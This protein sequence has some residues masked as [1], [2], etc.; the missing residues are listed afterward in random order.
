MK[1]LVAVLLVFTLAFSILP[2]DLIHPAMAALAETLDN[3]EMMTTV[4]PQRKSDNWTYYLT[5]HGIAV[6]EGYD[7]DVT[8]LKIP[9]KI[10]GY[11]VG[12]LADGAFA[13]QTRLTS[14]TIPTQVFEI[15]DQAFF[16]AANLRVTCYDGSPAKKWAQRNGAKV[17]SLT[18]MYLND[19]IID[20]SGVAGAERI[21]SGDTMTVTS[22][23]SYVLTAG[24]VFFFT[25]TDKYGM[26]FWGGRVL[27][28]QRGDGT[29]TVTFE[30][31][32]QQ[33]LIERIVASSDMDGIQYEFE[34]SAEMR[35]G[36]EAGVSACSISGNC[37]KIL[38]NDTKH[39]FTLKV[40]A[41]IK[42]NFDSTIGKSLKTNVNATLT[43]SF[44]TNQK[45]A[46]SFDFKAGDIT[47]F[48]T[49]LR[50]FVIHI[51]LIVKVEVDGSV[52]VDI[53]KVQE[54]NWNYDYKVNGFKI[55]KPVLTNRTTSKDVILE[56]KAKL[57]AS[58]S[59]AMQVIGI[60][61]MTIAVEGGVVAD[62][63]ANLATR[64]FDVSLHTYG[65]A[66]LSID[67]FGIWKKDKTYPIPAA[68]KS[69]FEAHFEYNSSTKKL[70]KFKYKDCKRRP[71][72]VKFVLNGGDSANSYTEKTVAWDTT[73]TV[74]APTRKG[75]NFKG[76]YTDQG[77]T[78]FWGKTSGRITADTTLYAKWE[79]KYVPVT[80]IFLNKTAAEL[81]T[82]GSNR[83]VQL[84]CT[85]LPANATDKTVTYTSSNPKVATV[86]KG[87]VTAVAPGTTTI[88]ATSNADKKLVSKCTVTVKQYVTGLAVSVAD[89]EIVKTATTTVQAVVTPKN[90]TNQQY[91]W[92]S[93]NKQVATVDSKGVVTGV[94]TGTAKIY[95]TAQDGSGVK[96]SAEVRVLPLPVASIQPEG[97][98]VTVWTTGTDASVQ[99]KPTVLPE[100]ADD[101]TLLW[102]SDDM[103]IADVDENGV[104]TGVTAGTTTIRAAAKSAPEVTA[105][106]EVIVKQGA[107]FLQLDQESLQL[108]PGDTAHLTVSAEPKDASEQHLRW[109]SSN[110][111]V[112]TV[113]EEGLVT[114]VGGGAA[115]ISVQ[116]TEGS[117]CAAQCQVNVSGTPVS[118]EPDPAV[119]VTG[120]IL[121]VTAARLGTKGNTTLQLMAA[122]QPA[123][124]RN[125][126]VVWSSSNPAVAVVDQNGVVTAVAAGE[127]DIQAVS[128]DNGNIS[129]TA[130]IVVEQR[131]ET[132]TLEPAS[133]TVYKGEEF[134]LTAAIQ[135]EAAADQRVRWLSDHPEIAQVTSKGVVR[136]IGVGT[137][138][139]TAEVL[140]GSGVC[141][142]MQV[143]VQPVPVASVSLDVKEAQM[144]TSGTLRQLQLKAAVLPAAA[145]DRSLTWTSSNHDAATVDE[146]GLVTAQ[147]VGTAIIT[148]TSRSDAQKSAQCTVTVRQY[149]TGIEVTAPQKRMVPEDTMQLTAKVTPDNASNPAI[150]WSSSQP[151]VLAVDEQGLLKALQLG[152]ATITA[153]AQDGSG[154]IGTITIEVAEEPVYTV[155]ISNSSLVLYTD[156]EDQA[157]QLT[158]E[159]L[160]VNATN[161]YVSWSSSAPDVAYVDG[162]GR[163]IGVSA[164]TAVIRVA[165]SANPEAFAECTVT[166]KQR[167]T[168]VAILAD[169][170]VMQMG[171][172]MQ[173]TA[174]VA[175][176]DATVSNV[177]WKSDN[178][179]VVTVNAD[180]LVKA[181]DV[182]T[183][184][185]TA[186]AT[187]GSGVYGTLSLTVE[188]WLSLSGEV[189][190]AKLYLAGSSDVRL[191]EL[192]VS[193]NAAQRLSD[194][195]LQPVWTLTGGGEHT[196]VTLEGYPVS[197]MLRDGDEKFMG[198][199]LNVAELLSGGTDTYTLT[200][201][202][203]DYS[204]STSFKVTCDASAYA[205]KVT[206]GFNDVTLSVG[207]ALMIPATPVGNGTLP[208]QLTLSVTGDVEDLELTQSCEGISVKANASSIYT[209]YVAY[210]TANLAYTTEVTLR[211]KGEDGLI[212]L[213][214]KSVVMSA[215][216]VSMLVDEALDLSAAGMYG[217]ETV[218]CE[219]VWSSSD[220]T[221]V[222]VDQQGHVTAKA[223]GDA[224]IYATVK[225]GTQYGWCIV[226]VGHLLQLTQ[227]EVEL[228]VNT[229][230]TQNTELANITLTLDSCQRIQAMGLQPVWSLDKT[231][232]NSVELAVQELELN[233]NDGSIIA[234]ALLRMVRCYAAGD[235]TY[236]LR[237]TVGSYT[238]QA[239][240]MI[241]AYTPKKPMPTQ[242][243]L[244][245]DTY[246]AQ[247]DQ[248]VL[249]MTAVSAEPD[250][251]ALP[252]DCEISLDM[253]ASFSRA[254]KDVTYT[255]EGIR[256]TFTKS[257]RYTGN[258]VFSGTNYSYEAPF[259]MTVADRDGNVAVPVD[260]VSISETVQHM[261][262]GDTLQMSAAVLPVEAGN[263]QIVWSSYDDAVAS[264]DENGLV[265]A[266]AAGMTVIKAGTEDS[267][268]FD[269]CAIFVED[270][271]TM[272]STS[273][274]LQVYLEGATHTVLNSYYLSYASSLRSAGKQAQWSLKRVSGSCL[275]L[276]FKETTAEAQ[277]GTVLLGAEVSL[278]GLTR[279]GIAVYDLTCTVGDETAT[280]RLTV[281]AL[282]RADVLPDDI[283]LITRIYKAKA[284]ELIVLD[285]EF[286]C[287]PA[288][289]ALPGDMRLSL[290]LDAQGAAA[291]NA[292]DYYISMARSALS[293]SQPGTYSADCVIFCG[294]VR[295]V[296]PVTFCIADESGFVPVFA[297]KL[298]C[299]PSELFMER[300][301]TAQLKTVVTPANATEQAVTYTS[302]NEGVAK[303][304]EKGLVTAV[305]NGFAQIRITPEDTHIAPVVCN[306]TVEKGF[307]VLAS[308]NG[309]TMYL[310]GK[311]QTALGYFALSDG[312]A[313]RLAL[314]GLYPEWKVERK[315]GDAAV[316]G[317]EITEDNSQ[318]TLMSEA[319]LRSGT[320]V[321][322]VSCTAGAYSWKQDF[323]L[324]VLDA[325]VQAPEQVLS[326]TSSVNMAVGEVRTID[327]TPVCKPEGTVLPEAIAENSLYSGLGD[328]YQALDFEHYADNGDEVTVAFTQPGTYL[329]AR[330]WIN[331]N[332]QYSALC[333][334]TVGGEE[335][336]SGLL[337]TSE[338]DCTVY[339]GGMSAIAA[340]VS[341][342]DSMANELL[343]DQVSWE[344][345]R[346]SGSSV[347]AA[348]VPRKD[349]ADLYVANVKSTGDDVWRLTYKLGQ[350]SES[351]DF[352]IHAIVPRSTLPEA[353]ILTNDSFRARAGEWMYISLN[354]A[355]Q[356]AGSRLPDTGRDFWTLQLQDVTDSGM[357]EIEN[358]DTGIRVRFVEVGAYTGT[359][360]YA[361]GNVWYEV[362][363]YFT[364]TDEEDEER[365]YELKLVSGAVLDTVWLDGLTDVSVVNLKLADRDNG[366]EAGAAA[367]LVKQHG[368]AW[369]VQVNSGAECGT[370]AIVE[371]VPGQA[372][373]VLTS[374]EHT[375]EMQY[376]VS[377]TVAGQTYTSQRTLHVVG[378]ET[379]KPVL[380]LSRNVYTL[381]EGETI[382]IDRRIMDMDHGVQLASADSSCWKNEAAIAAMG[383]GVETN[384]D[385]WQVTFYE[386]GEY[387]TSVQIVAGNLK[388]TLPLTFIVTA[389]GQATSGKTLMMPGKLVEIEEEAFVGL[390]IDTIDLRGSA[391]MVIGSRAFADNSRLTKV[392]LPASVRTIADDAFAGS[393]AAVIVCPAG[394]YAAAWASAHGL[395]V[396]YAK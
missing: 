320:D 178:A 306:V 25:G 260:S 230:G 318:L 208:E 333:V 210:E 166:V 164:G 344:L 368:A 57:G 37:T 65:D 262:V 388:Y 84:G 116:T 66:T 11:P 200:C 272:D 370:L 67:F 81:Y 227:N 148:A 154:V 274:T 92:T 103:S 95:A 110:P 284:N 367:A 18:N 55:P 338:T 243:A 6:I 217:S 182:G 273:D 82:T 393:T 309:Y 33:S 380:N 188:Q 141:A 241:H 303:V 391:I 285:T 172:T 78:K 155:Q 125:T 27:N 40:V 374:L 74:S 61:V 86:S 290:E 394:S 192:M 179:K 294:N 146:N 96:G 336:P 91:T 371:T 198:V 127:T 119:A 222:S 305:A 120:I 256:I 54:V 80:Q 384:Q 356:P 99:L 113:T 202:A 68:S 93:D 381:A 102:S 19:G 212:R 124:A 311:P 94:G 268:I 263:Q 347:T 224:M 4:S 184:T 60:D 271:L 266:H 15:G 190:D 88:T 28:V 135:P 342:T 129:V 280:T 291:V 236:I 312:T 90:A 239:S 221:V 244:V 169:T 161:K 183:A 136:P 126:D 349:G 194:A 287:V 335:R 331:M 142:S 283:Q 390:P 340:T 1:R 313:K 350:Y 345:T 79:S 58:I 43:T 12:K 373:V 259:T 167:V 299:L 70:D 151:R 343:E 191:A 240:V 377:C 226:H 385:T 175:P 122:V 328:F 330:T 171:D 354:A 187:D 63:A 223:P 316:F 361:A 220:E 26:N 351:I 250:G 211:V 123:N 46:K 72:S 107:Y 346:I 157:F 348:V 314:A 186:A 17:N 321:Y 231:N 156:G 201:T 307:S 49:Y 269:S 24:K 159:V 334:I 352:T 288:T 144:Y 205:D 329:L 185:I 109:T 249:L 130:H 149:V 255:A 366:V 254:V 363:V 245:T 2:L 281:Q 8:S 235:T 276:K 51:P 14:V 16:N 111:Y 237:C 193:V 375:G 41:E 153:E 29:A 36:M 73:L 209:L 238:A 215:D 118:V 289:A 253:G 286:Q 310:Q 83:T 35:A 386:K 302:T 69:I 30:R 251:A 138:N 165:S 252:E 45:I 297:E 279:T 131:A 199:R 258:V 365:G 39:N 218:D 158:A 147:G 114:A 97:T 323:T 22:A 162:N 104:V 121:N 206:P 353:I 163:V 378:G 32:E 298:I 101:L 13:A 112:A 53:Q 21:V 197:Y 341:I 52:S 324:T 98:Q 392:Y 160:P 89:E 261:M 300:G 108:D 174:A 7:G 387:H 270:G 62:V 301:D 189:A 139:I 87:F 360:R 128:Q 308:G 140:D 132:L 317:V 48:S 213:P 34:P 152:T 20:L 75:Y 319:L 50:G 134:T 339:A 282:N 216:S 364:V 327:F 168:S 396:E 9:T 85:V 23:M 304:D 133:K 137:A 357:V 31:V 59:I 315:S 362:P 389:Q 267:D 170:D 372:Q 275:T 195:G 265:T 277:D 56:A 359:L 180:G 176:S 177:T 234:G 5:S 248:S 214:V 100:N 10:D 233:Q 207:E 325:G 369:N 383:Y 106:Y 257:G 117:V 47:I 296:T 382:A 71:K 232:G 203:G 42:F 395:A 229:A 3:A 242:I 293:F 219:F 173:L 145:E 44:K 225:N 204:A 76:W 376:T 322:T 105:E 38:Y 332:L 326:R 196:R 379:P 358:G 247:V 355:T 246:Q 115:I 228:T 264:V 295:Y 181:V 150:T 278:Y 292:N 143:T 77:F 64:C 337:K